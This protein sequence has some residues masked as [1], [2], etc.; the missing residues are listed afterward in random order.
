MYVFLCVCACVCV[1]VCVEGKTKTMYLRIAHLFVFVRI[2]CSVVK[3]YSVSRA[4]NK[5]LLFFI[6]KPLEHS[7]DHIG[8]F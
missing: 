4:F 1:C 3:I 6:L 5:S 7:L 2:N 8:L